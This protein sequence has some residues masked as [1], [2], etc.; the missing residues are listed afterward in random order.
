M[1][2][3]DGWKMI[4]MNKRA[5]LFLVVFIS[6]FVGA[7]VSNAGDVVIVPG[8]FLLDGAESRQH[9][10]VLEKV[11]GVFTGTVDK[12]QLSSSDPNIVAIDQANGLAIP[13]QNG[14]AT[15]SAKTSKG[16]AT[17]KVTVKNFS[18]D[19]AWSFRNHVLPVLSKQGC[20]TGACHGAVTGKGGF[21]LS[22]R[23]WDAGGDFYNITREARGRRTE[24][25]DP[26]RS[27]L[28]TKP[29]MATPHK[30]GK[31]LDSRSRDYRVL[32]EWVANGIRPPGDTDPTLETIEIFPDVSILKRRSK[33]TFIVTAVYSDGKRE[34]VTDWAKFGSTDDTVANVDEDGNA[35]I[36][37]FGEGAVTAWF[38]SKIVIARMTSPFPNDLPEDIFTKAPKRNFIDELVLNQLQRLNLKP[39]RRSNDSEFIR[40]VY[41]DTIG[42]LPTVDETKKFLADKAPA[43]RD[44]LIEHLLGRKEFVDYWAYRWSDVFLV[45][46]RL[47][48]SD[49]V[50]VYYEW[51]RKGVKE[52]TPW[53]EMARQIVTAKGG[54]LEYG[55]TSFYGLH[56]DPE[57]M[58]E[59]VSQAFL[60][61]S[62]NCA[63]CHNH[64]MEK[65]TNDQYYAFANL[66]A[67][68]RAKGWADDSRATKG[69]RVIYI[70]PKGDLAQP[71]TGKPQ[72]PA[73]LD[74]DE[75][76]P[77]AT[78]DR[79]EH[80]AAWLT[81]P[82][83]DLFSRSIANRVW[84]AYFGKGLVD[85]VD[86]LRT[87]NPASNEP[88][89]AAL[90]EYVV[91]NKFDLK[92]MMRLVLQS[93][94]YQRSGEVLSEN[95]DDPRYLSRHYPRR[96]M[97]EIL[98]DAIVGV[99]G[100]P[101]KFENVSLK[102]GG[103]SKTEF[104]KEG[105]RALEL[106]DSSVE[107]YFLKTFGRNEREI[108]CECER[109]NQPSLVQILHLSNGEIL[110][111]RLKKKE[112]NVS[113]LLKSKKSDAEILEEV[114]L[115]CLSRLPTEKE[116]NG[117]LK[118][119]GGAPE[120]EKREAVEDLFWAIMTSR[121][122]LFQH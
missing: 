27:L 100:T 1:N 18:S 96:L 110:N 74:G 64:P 105:T 118:L 23:G 34:D 59:N 111:E 103:N 84:A 108:T 80:L 46:G 92:K 50:K 83:N 31:Q 51:I 90:A 122:F 25:A 112:S 15:I 102:G 54:D 97:A 65:W 91:T 33:Q 2:F 69:E 87:S 101:S 3:F 95:R 93:E 89:L 22:L 63:K 117:L 7:G 61:L 26:A 104:Y 16:V 76:D 98:H 67:R 12:A 24:P 29:T 48:R 38:S 114:Y 43:K 35:E 11:N 121:E 75:I 41:L 6:T 71:R 106:F 68:V 53:D 99:T 88:L 115:K 49:A 5:L 79:R 86:D 8:G 72:I 70:D 116:R 62:I 73:P 60:G 81:S 77:E 19:F 14:S 78:G 10:L 40:R 107:S 52:N 44:K 39:S 42:V 66:F 57:T 45:N 56:Q 32:S 28:L 85:P 13:K 17:A 9:I 37:G 94:T 58:A 119:M 55:A 21:R 36:I 4:G 47:L 109:S 120:K 113:A 30:G 20:N 82:D